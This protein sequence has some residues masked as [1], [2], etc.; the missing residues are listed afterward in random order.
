M[1]KRGK[2]KAQGFTLIELMVAM[3]ITVI[4]MAA[5]FTTFKSQ[6]DSFVV[7]DQVTR[8]QQNLRGAMYMMTRDI[9]MAGY[10]SNFDSGYCNNTDL[11]DDGTNESNVRPLIYGVPNNT[12]G[13]DKII[14]GTD[15]IVIVKASSERD[16]AGDLI[17]GGYLGPG[18]TATGTTLNVDLG[19]INLT[20]IKFGLLVKSDLDKADFF[21]ISSGNTLADSLS[22]S[23]GAGDRIFRA[24]VVIYRVGVASDE[25]EN[26]DRP[27][28][29]RKNLVSDNGFQIVAEDIESLQ[30]QY[31]F[32]DG[33]SDEDPSGRQ[34]SIRAVEV[35]LM[36]RTKKKIRGYTDPNTYNL[37]GT[38]VNLTADD[39]RHRRKV[40][41]SVIETRNIGL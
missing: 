4:V 2:K 8:M 19:P 26:S 23:Y 18:E 32:S 27:C 13:G 28:L 3:F 22:E 35:S 31:L 21:E 16:A 39:K 5:I 9:Q 20:G 34:A 11:D 30:V 38:D 14:N 12:T 33:T 40:L 37:G 7:Q 1:E 25:D 36:A 24:D 6:Q 29:R 10:Y 15:V 41:T 17:Y